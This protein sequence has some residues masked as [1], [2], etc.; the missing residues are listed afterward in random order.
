MLTA[1]TEIDI[2]VPME[3]V[4]EVLADYPGYTRLPGVTSAQVLRQGAEHPAG[5]GTLR[6]V[7]LRGNTVVEEITGFEPPRRLDYRITRSH[8]LKLLHEGGTMQ[9]TPTERGCRVVWSSTLGVGVP[10][11]GPA[12]TYPMRWLIER[13]FKEILL[14]IK[15]DLEGSGSS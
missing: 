7:R 11:L 15:H 13:T 1:K 6:E 4:W 8:P 5:I 2:D 9:L 12:L 3:R 14:F 10:L